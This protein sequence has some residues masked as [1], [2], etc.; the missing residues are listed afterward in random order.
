M[1][2]VLLVRHGQASFGAAE[3][4]ELSELGRE[5]SRIVGV[6]LAAQDVRVDRAVSGGLRR[7]RD[8]AELCLTAAGRATDVRV[9]P[10][11]DEYDHLG[12][13]AQLHDGPVPTSSRDF[14]AVLDVALEQWVSGAIVPEGMPAWG[15]FSD[16]AWAGLDEFVTALGRGGSGVV[17][18]S[19]GVIAAI[20]ARLLGLTPAGFVA[21][22]R[23]VINGGITKVVAGRGGTALISFNE[24]SHLPAAQV[25][26]R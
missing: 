18:T 26:Y 15:E 14:Q 16:R 19:G 9:D 24:H 3:Y 20:C 1:A 4:D 5:Q 17:F 10:R 2:V 6:N 12:L 21:L 13:A 25:T 22:H 8:T 7:Q 11:F 23:V